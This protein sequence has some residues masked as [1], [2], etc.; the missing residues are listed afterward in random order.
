MT[1]T[2]LREIA[3]RLRALDTSYDEVM[4]MLD[5]YADELEDIAIDIEQ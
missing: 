4:L 5:N 3:A 2:R 1:A